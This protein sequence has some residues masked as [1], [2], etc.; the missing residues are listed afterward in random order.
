LLCAPGNAGIAA[1]ALLVEVAADDVDR[2]VLT[3]V[4]EQVDLV[5]VGPE[6]P[7]VAGLADA[8][9]EAGVRCFGPSAA[10]ARLEGSKSFCKEV[11]SA[12]GVPTAGYQVVSDTGAGLA[13]I[14]G[15]PAV[16]KADGLAAGKGVVIAP[17]EPA[18]R[19][20]LDQLLV[21]HRFGTQRVVVEEYL[22]GTEL[23]LLALCDGRQ[24]LPL[25]SAQDYKRI[26]DGDQGP[27]T[28]GM[29][30]YSP[31]PA[32]DHERALQLCSEIHQPVLDEMA[33]R[34]IPFHGILYAG[35]MLSETGAKVLEFNVRFGDPETQAIL[36][37]LRSDLLELM[38]A[39]TRPG[40][41]AAVPPL[42]WS[43]ETAV[44]VVLAS[45]GYPESSSNGDEITG[46]DELPDGIHLTHA[47]TAR[48]P[49]GSLIT[50][51]GRV[52]S[53]TALG[54]SAVDARAAAYSAADMIRFEGRQLRRDIATGVG[55]S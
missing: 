41:L 53:V 23:S 11:M 18:A 22:R 25:A 24:A 37:R 28:G 32:V 13:A 46:L 39:A 19:M 52:I 45:R 12:A 10:A 16:I 17:D 21:E 7:L 2:L 30:S 38:Q 49:S 31:V 6:A 15:Y 1:D 55:A 51:G 36:P 29:G 5:V 43:P 48:N 9:D 20:A 14:K 3:A 27:N 47:G 54:R 40:G 8:L 35:L 33:R 44:S 42:E 26:Y 50:A 4:G 34:G